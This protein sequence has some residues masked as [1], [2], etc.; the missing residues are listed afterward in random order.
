ML[1][2]RPRRFTF[3]SGNAYERLLIDSAVWVDEAWLPPE[4]A[5]EALADL[6]AEHVRLVSDSRLALEALGEARR[7]AARASAAR[8]EAL[9][10]AIL[11][12][13]DPAAVKAKEPDAAA[14]A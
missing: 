2:V 8:A 5:C 7:A 1:R 11:A 13:T 4:E 9:T 3:M 12:A 10:A 6:K 14:V